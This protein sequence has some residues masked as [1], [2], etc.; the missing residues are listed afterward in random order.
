M[1]CREVWI[2]TVDLDTGTDFSAIPTDVLLA[3]IDDVT[4]VWDRRNQTPAL[5]FS[6]AGHHWGT[7]PVTVT[8]ELPDLAAR[9]TGRP[10]AGPLTSDGPLVDLPPWL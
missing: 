1:R 9:L 2:H 6:A 3:I 8:G 5:R 7:G 4:Q 10:N